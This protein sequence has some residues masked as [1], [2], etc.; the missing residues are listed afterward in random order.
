MSKGHT[1]GMAG[2]FSVMERL[3][4]LHHEA[5]LTLGNA[6]SIDILTK[7]PGGNLYQVSVKAI[8]GG[9]KWGVGKDKVDEEKNVVFVFLLYRDFDDLRSIPEAWVIPAK[10]VE[11][12]KRPWLNGAFAIFCGNE[13]DRDCIEPYKDQWEKYLA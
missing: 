3:F 2:E 5:A 11:E 8:R 10:K 12:L 7:S 4:R 6:K 9:G 1:T 13:R